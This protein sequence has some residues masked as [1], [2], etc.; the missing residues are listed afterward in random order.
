MQQNVYLALLVA[1]IQ[2]K[3][4]ENVLLA[5]VVLIK[6]NLVQLLVMNVLLQNILQNQKEILEQQVAKLANQVIIYQIIFV[7]QNVQN[8]VLE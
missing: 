2:T 4:K 5:Q 6:Q 8:V 1:S 3:V 7:H